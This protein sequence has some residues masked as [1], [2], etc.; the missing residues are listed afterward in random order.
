[1]YLRYK[2]VVQHDRPKVHWRQVEEIA[3]ALPEAGKRSVFRLRSPDEVHAEAE[4]PQRQPVHGPGGSLVNEVSPAEVNW[5]SNET[6]NRSIAS[7]S[8]LREY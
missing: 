4:S 1:M 6:N 8:R 3:E 7:S 2:V 5:L